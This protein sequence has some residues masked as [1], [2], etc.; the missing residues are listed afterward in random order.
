[1]GRRLRGSRPTTS[2]CGRPGVTA[3]GEGPGLWSDVAQPSKQESHDGTELGAESD[4]EAP[5]VGRRSAGTAARSLATSGEAGT[6]LNATAGGEYLLE[7]HGG[8]DAAVLFS[9]RAKP[10]PPPP[11]HRVVGAEQRSQASPAMGEVEADCK[12]APITC[13]GR[14]LSLSPAQAVVETAG[15]GRRRCASERQGWLPFP[16]RPHLD[17]Q[18]DPQVRVA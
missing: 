8:R 11:P 12:T 1:M 18:A 15:P 3:P 13:G 7:A 9:S 2:P 14:S 17:G 10:T 5:W 16:A 4:A 6:A